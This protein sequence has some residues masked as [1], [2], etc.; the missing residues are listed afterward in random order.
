M[1]KR[2]LVAIVL[3]ISFLGAIILGYFFNKEIIEVYMMVWM[4]V[5]AYEMTHTFTR[6]GYKVK[7]FPITLFAF[8]TYPLM[9]IAHEFANMGT[10][11]LIIMFV[12]TVFISMVEYTFSKDENI[13]ISDFVSTIFILVYPLFMIHLIYILTFNYYAVFVVAAC[14]TIPIF[15]D[16]FAYYFGKAFGKKKLCERVS[17]KKTIAGG[18]GSLIG[19][20]ASSVLIF[21]LFDLYSSALRKNEFVPFISHAVQ[22]WEW[23]NALIFIAIGLVT[24][25]VSQLGDLVASKIKRLMGIKDY[26]HIFP[27]HGGV[28][29]R[30]DSIISSCLVLLIFLTLIARIKG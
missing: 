30:L 11:M 2:T 22:G 23:K 6:K 5:A 29:D 26:G 17:P 9:R 12:L 1:L 8:L 25:V 21:I 10:E 27:G 28:M 20:A 14:V 3:L 15:S 18:I 19:A 7:K 24:G 13:A 16:A 4:L